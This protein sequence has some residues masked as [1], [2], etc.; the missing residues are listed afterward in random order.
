MKRYGLLSAV[1]LASGL[2]APA[3]AA[4]YY[5]AATVA[6]P[7]AQRIALKGVVWRCDDTGCSAGQGTSRPEAVCAAFVKKM[8]EVQ[9]F[10]VEGRALDAA[11]LEKCNTSARR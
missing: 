11:A 1:L 10:A 7:A 8:G 2:S 5:A 4:P 3:I 9:A 6:K